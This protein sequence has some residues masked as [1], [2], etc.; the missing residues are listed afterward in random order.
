MAVTNKTKKRTRKASSPPPEEAQFSVHEL[1]AINATIRD[2]APESR[3]Q[4]SFSA[5][6]CFRPRTVSS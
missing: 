2:T 4:F 1:Q 3:S 5:A 6:S